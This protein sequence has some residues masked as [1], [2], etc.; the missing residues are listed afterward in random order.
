MNQ[1][2]TRPEKR[3]YADRA[4]YNRS[5]Q[6]DYRRRQP[7][8]ATLSERVAHLELLVAGLVEAG[9]QH[10]DAAKLANGILEM[11]NAPQYGAFCERHGWVESLEEH[12]ASAHQPAA[13]SDEATGRK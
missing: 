3:T 13:F 12:I 5:Y 11:T 9:G 2:K 1:P 10:L 6:R 7:R 4:E 8:P